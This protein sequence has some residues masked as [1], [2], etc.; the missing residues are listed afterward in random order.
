VDRSDT[1]LPPGEREAALRRVRALALLMDSQWEIPGT[2]FRVG[3]DPIL[4]L[5]PG[6]GDALT[7]LISLYIVAEAKR[8]GV[9][10]RTLTRMLLNVGAD[11]FVGVIPLAGDVFDAAFRANARNLRLLELDLLEQQERQQ[12][13]TA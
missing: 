7:T 10:K 11:A 12:R 8:L 6:I 5:V 13:R 3:I 9:R 1:P 2:G 4:G